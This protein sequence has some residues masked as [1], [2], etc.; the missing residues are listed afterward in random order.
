MHTSL[1]EIFDKK[2]NDFVTQLWKSMIFEGFKIE[3][4]LYAAPA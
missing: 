3:E 2:T 4:G 1:K